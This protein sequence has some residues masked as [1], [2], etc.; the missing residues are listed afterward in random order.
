MSI[1]LVIVVF[2]A[3]RLY[4]LPKERELAEDATEEGQKKSVLRAAASQHYALMMSGDTDEHLLDLAHLRMK[5]HRL[6]AHELNL[7]GSSVDDSSLKHL[8]VT[9]KGIKAV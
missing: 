7:P 8:Q 4:I 3:W 5:Q 1:I 6:Q 9:A 2:P